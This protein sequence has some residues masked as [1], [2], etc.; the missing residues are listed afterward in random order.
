MSQTDVRPFQADND[1]EGNRVYAPADDTPA[2]AAGPLDEIKSGLKVWANLGL[3]LGD[4]I[5]AQTKSWRQLMAR[6]QH[7]TPIDY[8]IGVAGVYP[9]SGNLL[10]N[11]GTPDQGTRWEVT[12]CVVGGVDVFTTA[13]GKAGLYVSGM[14]PTTTGGLAPA[15][16]TALADQATAL[17]NVAFYGTRQLVV[18]DQ[19]YLFLIINGGTPGQTYAANFSATVFPVDAAGGRDVVTL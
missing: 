3:T 12:G 1:H 5:D 11:F 18:N 8:G 13:A 2:A 7:G 9:A 16:M 15:G 10:L 6:L 4:S 14:L 17:P 19:E